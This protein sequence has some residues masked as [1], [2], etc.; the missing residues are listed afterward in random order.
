MSRLGLRGFWRVMKEGLHGPRHTCFAQT[1][2]ESQGAESDLFPSKKNSH[3]TYLGKEI[4]I[5]HLICCCLVEVPSTPRMN[6]ASRSGNH[7]LQS[8]PPLSTTCI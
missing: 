7:P 2:E 1:G 8:N 3:K 5:L 6:F 4:L